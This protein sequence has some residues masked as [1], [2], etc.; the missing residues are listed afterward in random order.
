MDRFEGIK[1]NRRESG[2]AL[3]ISLQAVAARLCLPPSKSGK[4]VEAHLYIE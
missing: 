4:V 3:A 2:K 1:I